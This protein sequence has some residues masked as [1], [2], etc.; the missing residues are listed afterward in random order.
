MSS[1]F[2]PSH[3]DLPLSLTVKLNTAK[4]RKTDGV[5]STFRGDFGGK[6]DFFFSFFFL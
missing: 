4:E 2:I 3:S 6:G 5:V 1:F